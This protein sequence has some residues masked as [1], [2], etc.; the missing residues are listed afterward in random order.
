MK[1]STNLVKP[2]D[3]G[4]NPSICV[5]CLYGLQNQVLEL[6]K[7]GHTRK[8]IISLLKAYMTRKHPELKEAVKLYASHISFHRRQCLREEKQNI[9]I[10]RKAR[11][12]LK[13]QKKTIAQVN[14]MVMDHIVKGL[15]IADGITQEQ[16]DSMA[17]RDRMAIASEAAK[18]LQG[19]KKIVLEAQRNGMEKAKFLMETGKLASGSML[20]D[21]NEQEPELLLAP[22]EED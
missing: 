11:R 19:E 18:L 21:H 7:N 12:N 17:V 5:I 20:I 1:L 3:Q 22:A 4:P 13:M 9:A 16:I 10:V 6:E 14:E 15:S 8:R 2:E